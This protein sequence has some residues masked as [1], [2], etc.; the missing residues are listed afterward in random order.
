MACRT[1]RLKKVVAE[2]ESAD[3]PEP[4]SL[5]L[6][7]EWRAAVLRDRRAAGLPVPDEDRRP[8]GPAGALTVRQL[9]VLLLLV[10]GRSNADIAVQL[11]LSK[12]TVEHHVSA[13]MRQ[14]G[15]PDRT[16]AAHRAREHGY[17]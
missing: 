17:L 10:S 15:A 13:I 4:F 1:I 16:A 12:R 2:T 14:L 11:Y 3:L 9:D 8:A 7:G 6:A 5:M